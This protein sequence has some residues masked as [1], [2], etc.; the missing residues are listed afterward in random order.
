[1]VLGGEPPG[2]VGHC[3]ENFFWFGLDS[4]RPDSGPQQAPWRE[5]HGACFL[6]ARS[7]K[8]GGVLEDIVRGALAPDP[9]QDTLVDHVRQVAADRFCTDIWT[10]S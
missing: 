6:L 4:G 9:D 3:Q 7:R 2:R 10:Q 5:H 1:M 8:K